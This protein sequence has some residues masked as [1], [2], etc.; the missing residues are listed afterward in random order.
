MK[1]MGIIS[2]LPFARHL[3]VRRKYDDRARGIAARLRDS[4][5]RVFSDL[6]RNVNLIWW[7]EST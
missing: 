2:V 1:G 3:A 4:R 5:E 7:L 6:S